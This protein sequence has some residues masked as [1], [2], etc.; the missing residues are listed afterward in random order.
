MKLTT[1]FLFFL[2]QVIFSQNSTIRGVTIEES[3]GKPLI[4]VNV[5]IKSLKKATTSDADGKFIFTGIPVGKYEI[6]FSF[7]S[8]ESKI[9][10]DVETVANET[11]DMTVSLVEMKN[12]LQEVVIKKVKAKAESVNSLL[13]M[14]KN[15]VRVSDGISAET[16]KKTPDKTTSDVLK[17]ISGASVQDNKFVVIRGLNDRYNTSYLNGA[18]LP[19]S[20]PDRKAFSFDIFPANMIDNLVIYKTASPD[21]PGE[22]AG[23]V[24]DINTKATPDKSF[25]SISIGGGYNTITTGKKQVYY[26][27]GNTDWLGIDDGTRSLPSY[28]PSATQFQ[29]LQ[30]ANNQASITQ[31]ADIARR[32]QT[33]W[34]LY[35]KTFGPNTSFQYTIGN[36]F[37]MKNDQS[38]GF[39]AS[40]TYNKTNN[41][42]RTLRKSYE[43]PGALLTNQVDDS[44]SEQYLL[45]ALAN[46]SLKVDPNNTFTFKNLYSINSDNRVIERNG[47]LSQESD[48]LY[49]STTAR[50]FTSNEIYTGQLNGE[51]FL[52][53]SKIKISWVGSYSNIKRNIPN[54]RR[55]TYVYV[56]YDDGTQTNPYA[57]FSIN[58][59]GGESPGSMYVSK[60]LEDLYSTKIDINRKVKFG[61]NFSIDFKAGFFD[62]LRYRDFSARQL[63]YVP[64]NGT[65][66]GIH[67]G[68]STFSQTIP[69]LD[70][71]TIF[72]TSNIGIIS[73]GVSG[74]TIYDG[75]KGNDSYTA[76]SKL[77]AS[78]FMLDNSIFEKIR[79]IWGAR[80][81]NYSQILNSESDNG[82]PVKVN[83]SQ[84]DFL[85]S[86][87]LIYSVTKKQNI[88][89]SFS[90]T[91][92]RPEF[93][94][95][96][97]FL[98]YDAATKF[99]TEGTPDLKIAKIFN[100]D[101]RYEIF[102]GKG[103]LFSLSA[104]Y[105]KFDNPIELQAQANNTNQ[106][107][108]AKAAENKGIELEYRTLISSVFGTES[109]KLLDDI[110]FFTNIAVIR[111]KVDIS[112]IVS[113][114]TIKEIPLQGQSP[115]V[116]NAG[117]QYINS[118]LGW[119]LSAN[120]NKI[121]DRI[122][123]QAKQTQGEEVAATWEKGRTFLDLQVSKSFLKKSMEL[124][125]NVQNILAQDLLFYQNN[126]LGKTNATGVNKFL[127]SVFNGDPQNKNGYNPKED[128]LISLT[129]FGPTFSLT[130]SYTF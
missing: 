89:L 123:F 95:L 104:F 97:P 59:V 116:F 103:Q 92:N 128:D 106:Y 52:P 72:N 130:L 99:N 25:Q 5:V 56:K 60:N 41:Y 120:V 12:Q 31:I 46:V 122:A 62:Q 109:I 29:G 39:L 67:Y 69:F 58:N 65:V 125:L 91:L 126:D 36:S 73:P 83:N 74:L 28:F 102:P 9:I 101:L 34:K 32:F 121:G 113:S 23:G 93:R 117:F 64:F 27:G 68:N 124:K 17:R 81:E 127:N 94:E 11:F 53:K 14:Q 26:K 115:Y 75:T 21:L 15:S 112:N 7:V 119:S 100:A 111:S 20:E 105:K 19:S 63:G 77:N 33:D 8:F 42:N 4:G 51:H 44:Y 66:D 70:N 16:I 86:V 84:T 88:R 24:I 61:E 80:I 35:D 76:S 2:T 57:F 3:T 71:S 1:V 114:T 90:K 30:D 85:P 110:T 37:K 10:S 38:L 96:A 22:F 49:I 78:Y 6:E 107:K 108:N 45:G 82:S 13:S 50:M 87:N 118:E 47:S 48:P 79:I 18:P 55:N 54:E 43:T 98:F 129:K 40:V